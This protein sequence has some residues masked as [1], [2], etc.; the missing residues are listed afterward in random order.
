MARFNKDRLEDILR[1]IAGTLETKLYDGTSY[2]TIDSA[3]GALAVLELEHFEVHEG[4]FY[5][6]GNFDSSVDNAT[7]K[8]FSITTPDTS[9]RFHI[10]FNVITNAAA[11]VAFEENPTIGTVGTTLTAYNNNRNSSN[12]SSLT[13]CADPTG[14]VAGTTLD[15]HLIGTYNQKSRF[16]GS[17]RRYGE[18][19]LKQNED[20]L[21]KV[22]PDVDGSS[23]ALQAEWY[24]LY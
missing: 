24:E 13:V 1:K 2:N 20:Y 12:Q 18:W 23:I 8:L 16:G 9:R 19:I 11:Q 17:S 4:D 10:K 7:P 3:T 5:T 22:I 14:V 6:V 15:F 21:I